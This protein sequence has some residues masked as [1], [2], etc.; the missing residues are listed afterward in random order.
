MMRH[1]EMIGKIYNARNFP[2][3][4]SVKGSMSYG[5][6]PVLIIGIADTGD[7]NVLPLSRVK[8]RANIDKDYDVKLEPLNY[9]K[10]K[11]KDTSY[12]RVHKQN[13][14]HSDNFDFYI[15]DM[16]NDYPGKYK[17]IMDKLTEYNEKL[18]RKAL[19]N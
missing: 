2:F 11:L 6:R 4:D 7:C 3:F 15:G 19:G 5:N 16:A 1:S 8:N 14:I 10:L 9:P 18:L 12:I 17:D 13:L